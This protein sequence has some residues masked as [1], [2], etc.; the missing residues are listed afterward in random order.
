MMTNPDSSIAHTD[1]MY[2]SEFVDR[3][4][5]VCSQTQTEFHFRERPQNTI[6]RVSR[7][8]WL[9]M[10]DDA[11]SLTD[12]VLTSDEQI[13]MHAK[14][15]VDLRV[16]RTETNPPKS[17]TRTPAEYNQMVSDAL[18]RQ[19]WSLRLEQEAFGDV[20]QPK[21]R[22]LKLG[23]LFVKFETEQIQS[24]IQRR[25][26]GHLFGRFFFPLDEC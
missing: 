19:I 1:P 21:S 16:S 8:V 17:E 5:L 6:L 7:T 15:Q 2:F 20:D 25:P 26:R 22:Q 10:H 12:Q 11:V 9:A 23:S 3:D 24:R 13:V 18:E 4:G 14:A